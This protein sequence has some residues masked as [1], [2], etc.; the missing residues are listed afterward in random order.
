MDLKYLKDSFRRVISEMPKVLPQVPNKPI[1]DR[2]FANLSSISDGI[3]GLSV[4]KQKLPE[5]IALERELQ[6]QMNSEA[7]FIHAYY[8]EIAI[9]ILERLSP[10]IDIDLIVTGSE[11]AS[12]E[13][14]KKR[15]PQSRTRLFLVENRGR[16][17]FPFL[18][19]CDLHFTHGYQIFWKLHS[20]KSP[21]VTYGK[22]WLNG[23]TEGLQRLRQDPFLIRNAELEN[24]PL[25]AGVNPLPITHRRV[26]NIF[27]MGRLAKGAGKNEIFY[28]GTMFIGNGNALA[29]FAAENLIKFQPE[30]EDGQLDGTFGHAVER[31]FA[32]IVRKNQGLV[33]KLEY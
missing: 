31:T 8:P 15:F 18:L 14:V 26:F 7:I 1:A 22:E 2:T 11:L 19:L 5:S 17:V 20:K 9:E 30:H 21:H 27:W 12:L 23:I 3:Y 32:H 24:V 16:D 10:K 6:R 28:P 13:R 29:V 25:I 4:S 33:M